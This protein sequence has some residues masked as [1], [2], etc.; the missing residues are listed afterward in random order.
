MKAAL[1]ALGP[2][3]MWLAAAGQA[4]SQVP[5]LPPQTAAPVPQTPGVTFSQQP[6][7]PF[8]GSASMEKP[9][10]GVLALSLEEAVNRGLRFNLGVLLNQQNTQFA[11]GEK[12]RARSALLPN[13]RAD[14]A[15][16]DQQ[17]NLKALG[18]PGGF[19][20][21]PSIVGPFTVLDARAYVSQDVLNFN[22]LHNLRSATQNLRAARYSYSDARDI[23]AL[24]VAGL[25]LQASAGLARIDAAEAQVKTAQALYDQAV[26]K[27][28][29]GVVAGI[30]VTRAQVELQAQQQRLIFFQNEYE[31]Q[32]LNLA[33]AIGLP[34]GQQFELSTRIPYT[35]PPSVSY[36]QALDQA[37]RS[38]ADYQN[39]L[40]LLRSA[41]EARKAAAAQ[42]YPTLSADAN[43]GTIGPGLTDSHGTFSVS[44]TLS[45][46]VFRGGRIRG[47][48]LQAE[49]LL[50]QRRSESEDLRGRIDYEIRAA[51]LDLRANSEQVRVAESALK[52]A[53]Q[54][55]AQSR[56]RFAAGVADNIEVVQAQEAVA[57]ANE[58]Y[59]SSLYSYN[60]AKA[61]LARAI[62]AAEKTIIQFLEGTP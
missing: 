56:D 15:G 43:Y 18:F 17:I 39:A 35:P 25:Y 48:V 55:L 42:H 4:L 40:A 46:P 61:S 58:N 33:R 41:E 30:E 50:R 47:E 16:T 52:L 54:Q 37:Y 5:Q 8:L 29:A 14:I 23:V 1:I 38:R 10:P 27:R 2:V 34:L 51:F 21:V 45:V 11:L 60:L 28:G 49:A 36:E 19:P 62:G 22:A 12:Y 44:G 57:T 24:G 26:D 9:V 32:K 13:L 59:I 53:N 6:P 3:C 20:G 7:N 31:K